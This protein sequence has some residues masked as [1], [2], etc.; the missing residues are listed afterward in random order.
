MTAMPKALRADQA[1]RLT[2]IPHVGSAIAADLRCLGID[3]PQDVRGMNPVAAYED[4]CQGT[5]QRH[6]PCV[7][8]V[9]MAAHDFMNGGAPRPWWTFTAQRKAVWQTAGNRKTI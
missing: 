1:V 9:F 3:T 8:D 4:L 6:D 7:L 5:G 2:D